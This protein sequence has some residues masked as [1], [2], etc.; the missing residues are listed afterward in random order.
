MF[1]VEREGGGSVKEY[2]SGYTEEADYCPNCAGHISSFY[3]DGSQKCADCGYVF[4]VIGKE[5]ATNESN[6]T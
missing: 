3:G 1:E 6:N 2:V 5:M 4:Y